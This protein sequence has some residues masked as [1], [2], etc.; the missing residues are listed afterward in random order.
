MIGNAG[1]RKKVSKVGGRQ[2]S[3]R[4]TVRIFRS[5]RGRRQGRG[6]REIDRVGAKK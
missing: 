3:A 5:D 1:P 4:T 2:K 6:K